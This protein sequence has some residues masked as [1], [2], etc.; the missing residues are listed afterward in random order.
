MP[1]RSKRPFRRLHLEN[2]ENRIQPAAIQSLSLAL[3]SDAV[4]QA[5]QVEAAAAKG[6]IAVEYDASTATLDGLV[7]QL[8]AI[9][10][11]H[12]G[13][14][15]N[16][17]GLMAHGSSGAITVGPLD[18]LDRNDTTAT[19]PTWDRLRNVLTANARI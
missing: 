12:G 9:S 17:L 5:D 6:V 1:I 4:A 15:I 19:S 8:E 2:F 3:I 18:T 16:H 11:S 10:A 14:R 13:A 7:S